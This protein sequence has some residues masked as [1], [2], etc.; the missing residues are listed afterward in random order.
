MHPDW[1]S[2]AF[3]IADREGGTFV[4]SMFGPDTGG[5][6]GCN[7]M[8]VQGRVTFFQMACAS[9]SEALWSRYSLR[10]FT[11][12]LLQ[13]AHLRQ[14]LED[15]LRFLLVARDGRHCGAARCR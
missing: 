8:T 14:V 3:V 6:K 5:F 12:F 13:S 2:N 4:C 7:I 11:E 10:N 15:A 9:C 1:L